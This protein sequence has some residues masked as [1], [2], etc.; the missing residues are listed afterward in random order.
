MHHI[1]EARFIITCQSKI[2]LS[3]LVEYFPLILI[4]FQI[5]KQAPS[6]LHNV[7]EYN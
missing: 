6:V 4:F 1:S 7:L 5:L 3:D 2:H